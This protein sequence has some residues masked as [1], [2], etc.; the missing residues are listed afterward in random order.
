[1][2]RELQAVRGGVDTDTTR[3]GTELRNSCLE[4]VCP[5]SYLNM[6]SRDT[7]RLS[8]SAMLDRC[9]EAKI[10]GGSALFSPL[11]SVILLTKS[12]FKINPLF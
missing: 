10:D 9:L 3:V 7:S 5:R 6:A 1:M 4:N 12:S 2:R 11:A 8:H